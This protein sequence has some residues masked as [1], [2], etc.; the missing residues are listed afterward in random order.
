MDSLK[1]I[2]DGFF[3]LIGFIPAAILEFAGINNAGEHSTIV[4][5]ILMLIIIGIGLLIRFTKQ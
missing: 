5:L 1:S 3:G 2:F 4:G